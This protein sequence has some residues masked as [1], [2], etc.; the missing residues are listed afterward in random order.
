[1]TVA[2]KTLFTKRIILFISLGLIAFMLYFSY[3]VGVIGVIDLI[4]RANLLYYMA[5]FIAFLVAVFFSSLTWHS[6]LSSLSVKTSVRRVLL[7]MWVGMFFDVTVPEPGWS[8]DLLKVY[9]LAKTSG[10]ES[11]R[12]AASVVGQKVIGM[13]VTI[14]DLIL[15][16]ALLAWSYVLPS[17][18]LTFV[19]IVLSLSI[20]SL[21]IVVY[22]SAK[23]R[24]TKRILEWLIRAVFFIRRSRWNSMDFRL[25]AERM[26]NSFHE[27]IRTLSADK[28][29]L[30]RPVAFSL[31]SWA[32]DVSVV[33]LTFTALGCPVPVD[34]VLIVY[35]LTGTLQSI[36][37]SFLGFTE[38]IVSS[39]Y[40][41][42]GVPLALSLSATLLTRA[43]TLW[44]KLILAYV[45]FQW[46]G[47]KILLEKSTKTNAWQT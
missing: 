14:V 38:I 44:F 22:L 43:V 41:V 18:V 31:L 32:F 6:L 36:G 1:M 28:K 29:A 13:V 10:Q 39:S 23:P 20:F 5:A 42:L 25:K 7:F 30:A 17:L 45:A 9:M 12:I 11:G 33:F 15:G 27:G 26:L 47:L 2:L 3:F 37:I 34:K 4:K 24:A 35:A 21:F 8:G 40:T 19:A 46:A 16:L